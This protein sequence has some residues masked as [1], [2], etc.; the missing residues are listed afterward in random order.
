MGKSIVNKLGRIVLIFFLFLSCTYSQTDT[1]VFQGGNRVIGEVKNMQKGV[2][3]IDVPSGDENFKIKWL[4][5]EKIHTE[6]KFNVSVNDAIYHGRVASVS[7]KQIK[8]FDLDSTYVI[9]PVAK[10]IYLDQSNDGFANR[11]KALVELGFN[12]TKAQDLRQLSFRGDAGYHAERWSID[13]SYG[14]LRSTQD[15][16]D[17]IR[18]TDGLLNYRRVLWKSWYLI[19]TIATLSNTEQLIDLRANS[20]LGIGKFIFSNN[21]A[22]WGLKTGINNNTERFSSETSNTNTLEA[23]LGTELN[24]YDMGDLELNLGFLS[25]SGLTESGRYRID[26]NFDT[27]YDLPLDFFVRLGLSL[28]YDNQPAPNA[29]ETDYV[30]RSGIGWEW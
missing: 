30:I 11:F 8:I 13:L 23:F 29:S 27:K 15:N 18:R 16:A 10:V 25:Y 24:L 12:I 3:E 5:I 6:S 19:G 22:Y 4:E 14:I 9:V 1:I 17:P 26:L 20:Q 7:G 2:L 28:N 21:R